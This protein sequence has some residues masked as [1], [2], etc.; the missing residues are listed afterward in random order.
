VRF[1]KLRDFVIQTLRLSVN[2]ADALS[3]VRVGR[4]SELML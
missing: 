3:Y 4:F 1:V 2:P